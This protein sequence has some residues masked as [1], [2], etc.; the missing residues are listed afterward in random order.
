MVVRLPQYKWSNL[1]KYEYIENTNQ[2]KID[3]MI[4]TKNAHNKTALAAFTNMV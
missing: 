1:S 4:I 3:D 2:L